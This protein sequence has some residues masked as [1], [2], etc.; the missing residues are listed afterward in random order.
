M[1]FPNELHGVDAAVG[2]VPDI[3]CQEHPF[4]ISASNNLSIWSS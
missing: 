2:E 3:L 4:R 1:V